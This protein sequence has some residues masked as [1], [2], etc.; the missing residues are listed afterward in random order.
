MPPQSDP[1]L[2]PLLPTRGIPTGLETSI[3][4]THLGPVEAGPRQ[5]VPVHPFHVTALVPTTHGLGGGIVSLWE[6]VP[7]RGERS[8]WYGFPHRQGNDA[9]QT[10]RPRMYEWVSENPAET[11]KESHKKRDASMQ[12]LTTLAGGSC[13]WCYKMKKGCDPMEPCNRCSPKDPP[14]PCVRGGYSS[15]CMAPTIDRYELHPDSFRKAEDTLD[16]LK[17]D[18]HLSTCEISVCWIFCDAQDRETLTLV[19][20][21]L[22]LRQADATLEEKWVDL[23]LKFTPILPHCPNWSDD[24]HNIPNDAYRMFHLLVATKKLL[25]SSCFIGSVLVSTARAIVFYLMT[26]YVKELCKVSRRLAEKLYR[27]LNNKSS[28]TESKRYAIPVYLQTINGII[29]GLKG[30]WRDSLMSDIFA[31]M[32]PQLESVQRILHQLVLD[33]GFES[34]SSAYDG[35]DSNLCQ[36]D[37]M[38]GLSHEMPERFVPIG[39]P[40]GIHQSQ[41]R[42]PVNE[43]LRSDFD[44]SVENSA[45]DP[46]TINPSVI[47]PDMTWNNTIADYDASTTQYN[48]DNRAISSYDPGN[49]NT[50]ITYPPSDAPDLTPS[51]PESTSTDLDF[52]SHPVDFAYTGNH[53]S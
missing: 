44:E 5:I 20:D 9:D 15:L 12:R 6:H 31:H 38:I 4:N 16:Y 14:L 25:G 1:L 43:L 8:D 49:Q 33:E 2:D 41:Q 26:I 39:F 21:Q 18:L 40:Q 24:L 51:L 47:W 17:K 30:G 28:A 11:S 37:V 29:E 22:E 42:Y 3:E 7:V 48:S 36:F 50:E 32:H 34:A 19:A 53:W 35:F 13:I 27:V 10:S 52:K 45:T 23:A 46:E